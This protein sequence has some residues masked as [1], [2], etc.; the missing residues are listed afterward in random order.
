MGDVSVCVCERERERENE[1]EI[2]CLPLNR[3]T[4]GQ[5]KSDNNNRMIQLTEV[6]CVLVRYIMGP[7]VSDYNKQLITLTGD[8]IKRLSLYNKSRKLILRNAPSLISP[9]ELYIQL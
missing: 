1:S 9:D 5:H 3:I 8:Y 7:A 4:L 6:F 2:Q